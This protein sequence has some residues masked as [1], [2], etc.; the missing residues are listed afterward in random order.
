MNTKKATPLTAMALILATLLPG[1]ARARSVASIMPLMSRLLA[2]PVGS[3]GP[4]EAEG[5]AMA[6]DKALREGDPV[7]ADREW[8]LALEALPADAPPCTVRGVLLYAR[9]VA[10][11]HGATGGDEEDAPAATLATACTE[12]DVPDAERPMAGFLRA[13]V[14]AEANRGGAGSA[15][16]RPDAWVDLAAIQAWRERATAEVQGAGG[17]RPALIAALADEVVAMASEPSGPCD[18]AGAAALQA[19]QDGA[20]KRLEDLGRNDLV[21]SWRARKALRTD[22][23]IDRSQVQA[24]ADRL[25][26]PESAWMRESALSSAIGTIGT[27]TLLSADPGAIA[28]LCTALYEHLTAA[29][30]ADK[31]DGWQDRN[32][33]RLTGA[34]SSALSCPARERLD[35][36]MDDIMARAAAADDPGQ[37][38]LAILVGAGANLAQAAITGRMDLAFGA[39]DT[40]VRGLDRVRE[41]LGTTP[42]DEALKAT[43]AALVGVVRLLQTGDPAMVGQVAGAAQALAGVGRDGV[44][45]DAP[46]VVRLGPGFHMG[47]LGFL[48]LAQSI[49]G[50]AE[51]AEATLATLDQALEGDAEALL[52]NLGAGEHTEALV[53]TLRAARAVI[54]ALVAQDADGDDGG[55]AAKG[56]AGVT[57]ARAAVGA[58]LAP[59]AAETGWWAI[60]LDAGRLILADLLAMMASDHMPP[61]AVR[62]LLGQGQAVSQRLVDTALETFEIRGTGWELLAAIP[63]LHE[64]IGK[65]LG[66]ELSTE[67]T[68]KLVLA[69]VDAPVRE[70]LA[71]LASAVRTS[72]DRP[73]GYLDLTIDVLEMATEIGPTRFADALEDSLADLGRR[74]LARADAYPP[75]LRGYAQMGAGAVLWSK[76]RAAAEGA[77]RQ[78]V[79]TLGSSR[80]ARY[81]WL[82]QVA[83]AR[84]AA[85]D[86]D[87]KAALA[88]T[89][90]AL[91]VGVEAHGC[92]KAHAVDGLMPFRMTALEGLGKHDEARAAWRAWSELL[93]QGF[94]GDGTIQCQMM[95]YRGNVAANANIAHM[96]GAMMMPSGTNEGTFQVGLGFQSPVRHHDRIVCAAG[97][98]AAR[99]SDRIVG[100]HLAA[101][102]YALLAGKDDEAHASLL[103]AWSELRLAAFGAPAL[104]GRAAGAAAAD[105]RDK[106]PLSAVAWVATAARLRGHV[107]LAARIEEIGQV[108]AKSRGTTLLDSLEEDD[109]LPQIL[110]DVPGID[111]LGPA[112]RAWYT[113]TDEPGVEATRA[114]LLKATKAMKLAPSWAV[115]AAVEVLRAS[116]GDVQGAAKGLAAIKKPKDPVGHAVVS[117]LRTLLAQ[118]AGG[119]V[120]AAALEAA[121][122]ALAKAGLHGEAMGIAQQGAALLMGHQDRDGAIALLQRA[123]DALPADLAALPRADML[124]TLGEAWIGDG[125]LDLAA[126]ALD[127]MW[128]ELHGRIPPDQELQ[129]RMAYVNM[130]GGTGQWDALEGRIDEL[131]ALLGPTFGWSNPTVYHLRAAQA[132]IDALR[133]DVDASLIDATLEWA[134]QAQNADEATALLRAL[135]D[136]GNDAAARKTQAERY[137]AGLFGGGAP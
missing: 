18:T 61:D 77:L 6:G 28:P 58:A 87:M 117:S 19:A 39:A 133:G 60:G 67:Q 7:A 98:V 126:K 93:D 68:A 130:L 17:D 72:P 83:L 74:L 106:V 2:G 57:A 54:E 127:L 104:L 12:A 64:V 129:Q 103:D 135:R 110:E 132:A 131:V 76:D 66:Q 108:I 10:Q 81:A 11:A 9:S 75:D 21:V 63:P 121:V 70:A 31:A 123:V 73:L 95:S 102:L 112:V 82:P 79:D 86:G 62:E 47:A 78:A 94:G 89:D 34:F 88:A 45:E 4:S 107:H 3:M 55:D 40:L 24:L 22:G 56:A 53:R 36:L 37:A 5:H 137:L 35:G 42:A 46:L 14:F 90:A 51:A 69:A 134:D 27:A 99:R 65:T 26:R 50:D 118:V 114:A 128:T 20:R 41:R 120:D 23:S 48:A 136:G 80:M 32:V 92:G 113:T 125:R 15:A 29:V 59:G 84:L 109:S 111:A 13:L 96:P 115:P 44:T 16:E 30:R 91:A 8:R 85:S 116:V 52:R 38:I 43:L 101:G 49:Q 25:A 100:V 122:D 97:P 1:A 105:S 124:A 71:R 33:S 119:A